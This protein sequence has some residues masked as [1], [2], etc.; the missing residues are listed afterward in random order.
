MLRESKAGVLMEG[1][2]PKLGP[3]PRKPQSQPLTFQAGATHRSVK[4]RHPKLTGNG[5]Q[6][7]AT[8]DLISGPDL[9]LVLWMWGDGASSSPR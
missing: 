2:R 7:P 1:S 3:D 4:A 9:E 8:G 5:C 6:G